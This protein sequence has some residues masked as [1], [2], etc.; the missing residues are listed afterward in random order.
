MWI[1]KQ[2]QLCNRGNTRTRRG[3]SPTFFPKSIFFIS[4][5]KILRTTWL[6]NGKIYFIYLLFSRRV[7]NHKVERFTSNL[8]NNLGFRQ[9]SPHK[10]IAV[11]QLCLLLKPNDCHHWKIYSV[12]EYTSVERSD[13]WGLV[14]IES[15]MDLQRELEHISSDYR[16]VKK[17]NSLKSKKGHFWYKL[18]EIQKKS[19]NLTFSPQ[20]SSSFVLPLQHWWNVE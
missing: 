17:P 6:E 9:A 4:Y 11:Q 14:C 18:Q 19:H 15:N 3:S 1:R 2:P 10:V 16:T 8:Y 7:T 13:K 12:R 20:I 5:G